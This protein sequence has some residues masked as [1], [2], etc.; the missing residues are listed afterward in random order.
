[1]GLILIDFDFNRHKKAGGVLY[2]MN[3]LDE[4]AIISPSIQLINLSS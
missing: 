4:T 1:M 2:H 3:L